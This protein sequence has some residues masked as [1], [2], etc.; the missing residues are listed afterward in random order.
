[1]E[2]NEYTKEDIRCVKSA[3]D[4]EL[5]I[6]AAISCKLLLDGM[7]DFNQKEDDYWQTLAG[8]MGHVQPATVFVK[9]R[10]AKAIETEWFYDD[11]RHTRY[12]ANFNDDGTI[13][14][15]KNLGSKVNTDGRESYLTIDQ[16]EN[17][18][19]SSKVA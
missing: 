15:I 8:T 16:N 7:P 4:Y 18:Y 13:T 10:I 9:Q 12:E 1:M 11:R 17:L 5:S 2:K 3:P 14:Q 19:F 6:T